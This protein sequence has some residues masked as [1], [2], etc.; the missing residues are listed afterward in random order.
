[1]ST[2]GAAFCRGDNSYGQLGDGT[3]QTRLR[4]VRV[5]GGNFRQL[6]TGTFHS[7]G[8]GADGRG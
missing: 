1:M 6:S 5:S 2:T 8:I 3:L 7:C 4:P